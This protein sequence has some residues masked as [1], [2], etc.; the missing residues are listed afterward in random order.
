[1]FGV[2]GLAYGIYGNLGLHDSPPPGARATILP[3]EVGE[4]PYPLVVVDYSNVTLNEAPLPPERPIEGSG[5][6]P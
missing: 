5:L 1:M 2:D 4:A 6:L 3:G